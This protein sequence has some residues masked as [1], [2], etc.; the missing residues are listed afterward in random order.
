M[1]CCVVVLCKN[2]YSRCAVCRRAQAT[3]C[4]HMRQESILVLVHYANGAL[5]YI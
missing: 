2:G 5:Y 3:G 4:L 1:H